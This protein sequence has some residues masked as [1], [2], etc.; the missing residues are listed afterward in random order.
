MRRANRARPLERAS[1]TQPTRDPDTPCT[2]TR[3]PSLWTT[4]PGY[5]YLNV[6][7]L[8]SFTNHSGRKIKDKTK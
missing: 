1:R 5:L 8:A 6:K 7:K 3:T 2:R 4:L